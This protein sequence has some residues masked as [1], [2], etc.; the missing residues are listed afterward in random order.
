MKDECRSVAII[1]GGCSGTL[2]AAHLAREAMAPTVI[3]LVD[4][5]PSPARGV[6]YATTHPLH[7]LNVR[8][9]RMS[10]FEDDPAHF[11]RWLRETGALGRSWSDTDFAPRGLYGTYLEELLRRAARQN[12]AA[13][14]RPVKGNATTLRGTRDG[15][16]ITLEDGGRI[17]ADCAVLCLGNAPPRASEPLRHVASAARVIADPWNEAARRQIAPD[18]RVLFVGT[19]LTMVDLTLE[20]AERG[21]RAPLHAVSR[22]GLVP[23]KHASPTPYPAFLDRGHLPRSIRAQWLLFRV[24]VARAAERGVDWRDVFDAMRPVIQD[25]WHALPPEERRRFL[26]HM[27]PYFDTHRHRMAPEVAYRFDELR[28][29]GRLTVDAAR[30]VDVSGPEPFRVSLLP[31]GR[32]EISTIEADWIVNCTGP[33]AT[34]RARGDTLVEDLIAAGLGRPD[35]LGLG[36][37][38][39]PESAL[40]DTEGRPS[41]T[42][43][44]IGALT[45]GALWD[46][47]AVPDIR[48][49]CA[50][51]ARELMARPTPYR[52]AAQV[53][54]RKGL[55]GAQSAG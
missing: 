40:I 30:I 33:D 47:T 38:V 18:D 11:R 54:Q 25:L 10:A 28:R 12:E 20:L 39:T 32:Q 29:I 6:A 13:S 23:Q 36:L 17:D 49:Q 53:E 21:H 42:L 34:F 45:R 41:R 44:A 16:T 48:K 24:E 55:I 9:G 51:I 52:P 27:R 7:L 5:S 50:A 22:H 2:L 15:V 1:G 8:V 46:I 14:I 26:R 35:P 37:D 31:R 4:R 3:H 19:G 43:Y